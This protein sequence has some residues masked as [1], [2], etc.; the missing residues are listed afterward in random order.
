MK[1]APIKSFS[2]PPE[3][4]WIKYV[5]KYVLKHYSIRTEQA[6]TDWIKRFILYFDK[7]HPRDMSAAEVEQFLNPFG[8]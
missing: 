1:A 3:N 7:Q 4:Y 6:Y 5:E 8:R 2:L